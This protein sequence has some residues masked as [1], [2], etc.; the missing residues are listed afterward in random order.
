MSEMVERIAKD[1]QESKRW[2]AVFRAGEA[3]DLVRFVIV[4]MRE[5]TKEMV[6]EAWRMIGSNLR[7]EEVYRHMIDE[8]TK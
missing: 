6:N 1:L 4:R 2:P 3:E 8:A 7:Y 5:P